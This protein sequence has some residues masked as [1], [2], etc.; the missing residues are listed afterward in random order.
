MIC[1]HDNQEDA[2]PK[3]CNTRQLPF[4]SKFER[5]V[6]IGTSKSD[7]TALHNVVPWIILLAACN[8]K[9]SS[10]TPSNSH[11][12]GR[13]ESVY[14]TSVTQC[15]HAGSVP[16]PVI[17]LNFSSP[18]LLAPP[19]ALILD[20]LILEY[21]WSEIQRDFPEI[22]KCMAVKTVL[23]DCERNFCESR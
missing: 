20:P 13:D 23:F 16:R 5:R 7:A 4:A 21:T 22:L 11:Y 2:C 10:S 14:K 3:P 17:R 19:S 15:C 1:R 12:I 6:D 18:G 9:T 8:R